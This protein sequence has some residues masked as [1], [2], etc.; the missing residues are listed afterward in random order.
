MK[1]R[2]I[3]TLTKYSVLIKFLISGGI[4]TTIDLIIYM[5]ISCYINISVA[6]MVS[7]LIAMSISF[8]INKYWSFKASADNV[9]KS[10]IKFIMSQS[11]NLISN[12]GVNFII[13]ILSKNKIISFLFATG[14]STIINFL[15][16]KY[17]VF[18]LREVPK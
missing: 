3:T 14:V 1:Q 18:K 11:I 13:F 15:L 12:T 8:C 17:Y 7:M 2:L 16:Q 5:I 4:T 10:V 9:Y 6:K